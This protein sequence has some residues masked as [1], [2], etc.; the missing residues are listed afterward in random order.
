[1][2]GGQFFLK[3]LNPSRPMTPIN[4]HYKNIGVIDESLRVKFV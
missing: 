2:D 3:V 1:M 4:E